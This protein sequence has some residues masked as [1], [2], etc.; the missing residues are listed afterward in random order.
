MKLDIQR[1]A[2]PYVNFKDLPSQET[3]LCSFNLNKL[4]TNARDEIGDLSDLET[5]SK[6]NLVA[7]VNSLAAVGGDTMPI[8]AILPFSGSTIP[9]NFLLADGSA[10]SRETYSELFALIG[11]TYGSGN[12]STT[13]NLPNLKGR[14]P[15]GLDSNDSDLSVL[16]NSAG[17]KKHKLVESELPEISAWWAI[18]GQEG[19]TIF[20]TLN[21]KATGTRYG[22]YKTTQGGT[23]GGAQ[24]YQ[25]PGIKFGQN[26][27]HNNMQPYVVV[28]YIIKVKM[29]SG[30]NGS[31]VDMYSNSTTDAY[32]AH[33]VNSLLNPATTFYKDTATNIDFGTSYVTIPFDSQTT[34]N[35]NLELQNDGSVKIIGN[36]SK[37]MV[38]GATSLSGVDG[39]DIRRLSILKNDV[40]VARTQ[41]NYSSYQSFSIAPHV[42]DVQQNDVIKLG[43]KGEKAN[44]GSAATKS[45]VTYMTIYVLR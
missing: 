10:V 24:S 3:A 19:G 6:L 44:S 7:A 25:N 21:G 38:S 14:V 28:N 8:G 34:N 35:E 11:T 36:I 43:I 12:G 41:M 42:I 31:V 13:F 30:L 29:G 26:G 1:F 5:P 45:D 2:S 15:V 4:Q 27:L 22:S 18:H 16:G 23:L 33:Y 9:N 39:S 32:S 20:Y 40:V 37:I 17:E